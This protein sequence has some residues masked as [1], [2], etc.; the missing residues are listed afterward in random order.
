MT[1]SA[2]PEFKRFNIQ[3]STRLGGEVVG[4]L[5]N[6]SHGQLP[7]YLM[8]VQSNLAT[9]ERS[10][11]RS[12]EGGT[13]SHDKEAPVPEWCAVP[14]VNSDQH[15]VCLVIPQ[16][17]DAAATTT[18]SWE[19]IPLAKVLSFS[20]TDPSTLNA[21]RSVVTSGQRSQRHQ[22]GLWANLSSVDLRSLDVKSVLDVDDEM[23]DALGG[24]DDERKVAKLYSERRRR[25]LDDARDALDPNGEW[26]KVGA[27]DGV[28]DTGDGGAGGAEDNKHAAKGGPRGFI[29]GLRGSKEPL[30]VWSGAGIGG[31]KRARAPDVTAD[32]AM[33]QKKAPRLEEPSAGSM[34][35]PMASDIVSPATRTELLAQLSSHQGIQQLLLNA[36]GSAGDGS[37]PQPVDAVLKLAMPHL[38]ATAEIKQRGRDDQ[39]KFVNELRKIISDFIQSRNLAP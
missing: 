3:V 35:P 27:S 6:K 14:A 5:C 12:L 7:Q 2:K 15:R 26:R 34:P 20:H 19:I 4:C 8:E 37:Q 22:S 16:S 10:F 29:S 13:L 23:E 25:A 32:Q 21:H 11:F 28:D 1:S 36:P 33:L 24:Q 39:K 9:A 18:S 31:E 38:S 17:S 30:P